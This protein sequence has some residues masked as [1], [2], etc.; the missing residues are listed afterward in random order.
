MLTDI[1]HNYKRLQ[2]KIEIYQ[3]NME[4]LVDFEDY[5]DLQ[6]SK[7]DFL[8]YDIGDFISKSFMLYARLNE[9]DI[10]SIINAFDKVYLMDA[11]GLLSNKDFDLLNGKFEDIEKIYINPVGDVRN[12]IKD[13]YDKNPI[14]FQ[15]LLWVK[16]HIMEEILDFK[17]IS[18]SSIMAKYY[19]L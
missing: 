11:P 4:D 17:N 7:R 19:K 18:I 10:E 12:I 14:L 9:Y 15:I 6:G 5:E 13:L 8:L 2:N 16:I 1:K 3:Q